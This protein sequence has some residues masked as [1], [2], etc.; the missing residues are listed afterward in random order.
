M[1]IKSYGLKGIIKSKLVSNNY[2]ILLQDQYL[3][4]GKDGVDKAI[5]FYGLNPMA[6]YKII[7]TEI[8]AMKSINILGDYNTQSK[9]EALYHFNRIVKIYERN[10]T[11]KSRAPR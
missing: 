11:K 10:K 4:Y 3:L 5:A 8:Y 9:L 2:V 6:R 7:A 1:P